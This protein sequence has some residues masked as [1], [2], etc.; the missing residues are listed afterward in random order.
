MGWH[1]QGKVPTVMTRVRGAV[2]ETIMAWGALL[3][4]IPGQQALS[5]GPWVVAEGGM[6]PRLVVCEDSSA[7]LQAIT[8][9]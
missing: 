7:P 5:T 4:E 3:S 8:V 9:A 6:E 1:W 2:L